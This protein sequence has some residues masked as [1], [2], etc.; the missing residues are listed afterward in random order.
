MQVVATPYDQ[1]ILLGTRWGH[2]IALRCDPFQTASLAL[3][4]EWARG[5]A[6]AICSFLKPGDLAIDVGA[7]IGTLT[8]PMAKRVGSG[9]MVIAIEPQR[10]PFLCLCGNVALTHCLTQ[11]R[12]L[13]AAAGDVE[14]II[15]VPVVDINKPFN[16]GGVRLQDANYDAAVNLKKE[17][18]QMLTIDSMNLP[19]VSLIKIDVETMEAK[20]LAGAYDTV[21]RCRPVIC[22]EAL[23]EAF[24]PDG[25]IESRN[26]ESMKA[27]FRE[28]NY[29][30]RYFI[31]QLFDE[32]N[33]RYCPDNIFPG[34][35]RNII[36]I[37]SEHEK[38][39]WWTKLEPV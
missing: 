13:N 16:V 24:N 19:R 34:H 27:F 4:G 38:P 26:V 10:S 17:N 15:Q 22:A 1:T 8:I 7:N 18:V 37:P 11:V 21:Q 5:E 29:E 3:Y 30:P 20:V 33:N 31:S 9:G 6:D 12:C 36:A 28:T 32:N 23:F 2:M 35:D 39:E 25:T 14:E